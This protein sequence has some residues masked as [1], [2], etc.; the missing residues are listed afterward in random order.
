MNRLIVPLLFSSVL[1]IRAESL[2]DVLARL[3]KSAQS[4]QGMSAQLTQVTHTEIINENET[5][6]STVRMKKGKAGGIFG[7]VDFSGPNQMIVG[8]R[9]REVQKYYPKS[10]NVEVYDVGKFGD[11][12]DQFLLLGFSTSGKDLQKNYKL[13]LLGQEAVAGRQATHLELTP[14]SKEA[15]DIFKKAEL[16]LA[17]DANHPVQEKIF[18]ND[19][20]YTLITYSDVKLNPPLNDKDLELNLPAGVKRITPQK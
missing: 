8:I 2:N 20:D 17:V 13:K 12:L 9:D 16:W 14:K 4:F 1:T 3:D 7:R 10:N 18:K 11:Q 5:Q 15:Q 6:K 19:Q